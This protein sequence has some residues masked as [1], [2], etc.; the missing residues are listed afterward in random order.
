MKPPKRAVANRAKP[1]RG[2]RKQTKGKMSASRARYAVT[3]LKAKKIVV[4]PSVLFVNSVAP[5]Y[6][7]PYGSTENLYGM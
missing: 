3:L 2:C 4:V 6:V 1:K 7:T 5:G